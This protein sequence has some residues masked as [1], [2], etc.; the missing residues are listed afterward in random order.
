MAF[1]NKEL[2]DRRFTNIKGL[3]RQ[4]DQ[5]VKRGG[6]VNDFKN[7]IK[8]LDETIEDLESIIEQEARILRNG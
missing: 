2:V 1:R 7:T 3:V 6:N 5:L 4:L 8:R